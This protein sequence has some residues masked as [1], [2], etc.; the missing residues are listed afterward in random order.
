[1]DPPYNLLKS[2][3][4][5]SGCTR[6]GTPYGAGDGCEPTVGGDDT[7]ECVLREEVT[8]EDTN[9]GRYKAGRNR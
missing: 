3:A 2:C 5:A 6:V 7:V 1:V 8:I 9:N 4:P